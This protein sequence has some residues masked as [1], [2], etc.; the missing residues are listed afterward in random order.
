MS[1]YTVKQ[2]QDMARGTEIIEGL[3]TA[4]FEVRYQADPEW[5]GFVYKP[6]IEGIDISE[7]G[8]EINLTAP[9]C[10]RGC[11]GSDYEQHFVGWEALL[12]TPEQIRAVVEARLAAEEEAKRKEKEAAARKRKADK[13]RREREKVVKERERL[14]ELAAKYPEEVLS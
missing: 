7:E 1:Q 3:A 5:Q 9:A 13:A 11:C 10:T 12:Q 4:Y 6:G 14:K 8:V 2:L